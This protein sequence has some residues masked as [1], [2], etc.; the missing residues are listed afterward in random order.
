MLKYGVSVKDEQRTKAYR[1]QDYAKRHPG[2]DTMADHDLL[3]DASKRLV[4]SKT[5]VDIYR[6]MTPGQGGKS[7][8]ELCRDIAINQSGYT[9]KAGDEKGFVNIYKGYCFDPLDNDDAIYSGREIYPRGKNRYGYDNDGSDA[10]AEYVANR[11][12]R[13]PKVATG[14]R[15]SIYHK[16]FEE[17]WAEAFE[18]ELHDL[19][20][21]AGEYAHNAALGD[22]YAEDDALEIA[23]EEMEHFLDTYYDHWSDEEIE[24]ISSIEELTQVQA[25]RHA[26]EMANHFWD[27]MLTHE[28]EPKPGSKRYGVIPLSVYNT[29]DNKHRYN[30]CSIHRPLKEGEDLEFNGRKLRQN[31]TKAERD[32]LDRSGSAGAKRVRKADDSD[33]VKES[34]DAQAD[35]E[36]AMPGNVNPTQRLNDA[37]RAH[38]NRPMGK[39]FT[40]DKMWTADEFRYSG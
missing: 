33:T 11:K 39:S 10:A 24:G 28:Y 25:K 14:E 31:L 6:A 40:D 36:N 3:R 23:A 4:G 38:L 22:R 32:A 7:F 19:L 1:S 15:N 29:V 21:G 9:P 5:S 18:K 20:N 13:N 2:V 30:L 35:H 34:D 37:I 17:T 16:Q 26:G 8:K 27:T 12:G